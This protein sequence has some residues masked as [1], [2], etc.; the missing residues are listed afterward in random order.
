M[1]TE[2]YIYREERVE[3][4]PSYIVRNLESDYRTVVRYNVLPDMEF[5]KFKRIAKT[6][7]RD[8][9]QYHLEVSLGFWL[10]LRTSC[11]LRHGCNNLV[12]MI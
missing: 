9:F 5:Y 8:S 10:I 12:S 3:A 2:F 6:L 4:T 11:G 1:G 7:V